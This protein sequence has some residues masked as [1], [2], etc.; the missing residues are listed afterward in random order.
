MPVY[1]VTFVGSNCIVMATAIE[2][3]SDDEDHI[4]ECA[5]RTLKE[6]HDLNPYDHGLYFDIAEEIDDW[7]M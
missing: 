1:N 7:H 6:E 5:L 4:E 2:T 3:V